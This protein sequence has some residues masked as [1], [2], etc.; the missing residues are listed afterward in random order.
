MKAFSG[1]K[2]NIGYRNTDAQIFQKA[3]AYY[4]HFLFK[5]RGW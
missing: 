4:M 3:Q 1:K 5:Q 2:I